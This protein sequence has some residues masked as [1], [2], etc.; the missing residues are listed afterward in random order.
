MLKGIHQLPALRVVRGGFFA[1]VA[2]ALMLALVPAAGGAQSLADKLKALTQ[3]PGGQPAAK[4]GQPAAKPGQVAA[5]PA[6]GDSGPFTA[7]AGTVITPVMIGPSSIPMSSVSVS[8]MGVHASVT[9]QSGSRLVVLL[10]GVPGPKAGQDADGRGTGW[11]DL[12]AGRNPL[13]VLC[14][15]RLAVGGV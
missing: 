3:K 11:R 1:A 7:P 15:D 14:R 8:P 2:T 5:G 9:T 4:P 10:D 12:L 13:G 6:A